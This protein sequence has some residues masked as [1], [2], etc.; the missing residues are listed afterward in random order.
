MSSE[1][2]KL[3]FANDVPGSLAKGG[4]ILFEGYFPLLALFP[5][6]A[7]LPPFFVSFWF[8]II[9]VIEW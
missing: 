9:V 2:R 5:H 7:I 6:R 1:V 4:L 3:A 8:V